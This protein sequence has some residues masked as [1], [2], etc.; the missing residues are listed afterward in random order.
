MK[1]A[2]LGDIA[3][4]GKYDLSQ[5]PFA[6]ERLQIIA[7]KLSE[8][9]YVVANLETPLT[10][11]TK[12]MVCKSMHLKTPPENVELLKF[13]HVNAVSL[14]NNHLN[15]YGRQGLNDTINT[16][17]QNGIE[18]FGANSKQ[19]IKDIKGEKVCLSGFCCYSTNGTGYLDNTSKYGVNTLTYDNVIKQLETDKKNNVFSIMSFHWGDEHTDY[20]K[21]EHICLAELIAKQK[22]ALIVGH[23][24]HIIQGVQKIIHSLVA[25]SLGN[26][27]FD[28]MVSI[29]GNFSLKQNLNNKMSFI[30]EVDIVNASINSY[31]YYGFRDELD[32][33]ELFDINDKLNQISGK[34][35]N[36]NDI[37]AYEAIRKSQINKVIL[38]KFGKHDLKWF[39]SRLNYY[40]VGAYISGKLRKKKYIKEATKFLSRKIQM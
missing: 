1:I 24:P 18:W 17:Q 7:D 34:L 2:F 29:N 35:A 13:L 12:T 3:L 21:Y 28:D 37:A 27:L 6:K 8:F 5:N 31:Q 22:D 16:L 14:S 4:I 39:S 40:S 23:H 30:L 32:K 33:I 15:D 20:P 11:K 19:L 26:F 38:E 36:I 9:D 25:Y 10:R